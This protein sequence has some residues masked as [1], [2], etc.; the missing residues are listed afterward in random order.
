MTE[1]G[2]VTKACRLGL[3]IGLVLAAAACGPTQ[4]S[5][6]YR[7]EGSS[8]AAP[9]QSSRLALR[10]GPFDFPDYL[11]QPQIVTRGGG[12]VIVIDEFQRWAGSLD[13]N[14]HRA[15]SED[16][17]RLVGT[18]QVSFYPNEPWFD[19]DRQLVGEILAFDG[20]L[21]GEVVLDVRW[22][23]RDPGRDRILA[24]GRRT[25]S[26][27]ARDDSY[28]ALVEAHERLVE[29]FAGEVAAEMAAL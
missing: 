23:I 18:S 24:H 26:E 4:P 20:A 16:L 21:G 8:T 27:P 29:R 1:S 9:E 7:L 19:A 6:F 11:D 17:M 10:V 5:T 28:I 13:E 2:F 12:P 15:L 3:C 25:L 14:F 22:Q